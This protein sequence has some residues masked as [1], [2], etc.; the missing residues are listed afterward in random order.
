[1]MNICNFC[2]SE[3]KSKAKNRKYCS[4]SCYYKSRIGKKFSKIR[5]ENI[6][7]AL[8]GYKHNDKFRE[9]AR[10][11]QLGKTPTKEQ[12]EKRSESLKKRHQ[13]KEWGFKKGMVAWNKGLEGFQ[14]GI[15]RHN[16]DADFRRKI[17]EDVKNRGQ[18]WRDKL[19]VIQI[20]KIKDK[21]IPIKDTK[22]ELLMEKF[23]KN[24]KID[25]VK[26]WDYKYG[27]ADFLI[28]ARRWVIEVD[29]DYWHTLPKREEKD[30]VKTRYLEEE[31]YDVLRIW[32]SEMKK[33][34]EYVFEKINKVIRGEMKCR[35]RFRDIV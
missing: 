30:K 6:S 20:Q 5:R 19:R 31:G 25:Y 9:K 3:Y 27:I 17:S 1:M 10:L 13:E 33:N 4:Q 21:K 12:N 26:H 34:I 35:N 23:L 28:P 2:K 7:N 16:Y 8:L 29:G 18:E 24:N 32:T 14:K 11:R 22:P 15:P